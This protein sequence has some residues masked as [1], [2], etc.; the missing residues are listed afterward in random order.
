MLHQ[1]T[2]HHHRR[3]RQRKQ[4]TTWVPGTI[5]IW[6]CFKR[7]IVIVFRQVK[8][9]STTS[10]SGTPFEMKF[11]ANSKQ[12]KPA[13]KN[14]QIVVPLP[15]SNTGDSKKKAVYSRTIELIGDKV[16]IE[17]LRAIWND[18]NVTYTDDELCRI[19][20]WFYMVAEIAVSS[21]N[22]QTAEQQSTQSI[23]IPLPIPANN[24]TQHEGSQESYSLHPGIYRRAS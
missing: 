22:R 23:A 19:R 1:S 9:L 8:Y 15:P 10:K 21:Y 7:Q 14:K 12:E 13:K 2:S 11:Q 3:Q 4:T 20:D 5:A 16:S 6:R 24:T 18:E 17:Q